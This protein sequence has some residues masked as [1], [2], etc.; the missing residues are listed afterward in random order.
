MCRK[1]RQVNRIVLST[2]SI[3]LTIGHSKEV[4][5]EDRVIKVTLLGLS[6]DRTITETE[7]EQ[8]HL[9]IVHCVVKI[10]MLR[11]KG[12]ATWLVMTV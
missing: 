2:L 12:A 5:E 10:I 6:R 7:Q 4:T 11:P 9:G 8:G 1:V 3:K